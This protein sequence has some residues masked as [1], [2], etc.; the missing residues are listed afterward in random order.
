VTL[1]GVTLPGGPAVPDSSGD[2]GGG[3]AVRVAPAAPERRRRRAPGRP[4]GAV[5]APE[6]RR[7]R[8]F[9]PY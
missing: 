1:P 8:G 4:A 6:R 7:R 2:A 9:V 5:H 3:V